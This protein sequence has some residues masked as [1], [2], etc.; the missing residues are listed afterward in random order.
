[1]GYKADLDR[2]Y[3][4]AINFAKY[5]GMDTTSAYST[6]DGSFDAFR[7]AYASAR[8]TQEYGENLAEWASWYRESI[9]GGGS[10]SGGSARDMDVAN[11][12]VGRS[13]AGEVTNPYETAQRALR[14]LVNGELTVINPP[15]REDLVILKNPRNFSECFGP[16][17]P[18]DMWPLD[19]AFAPDPNNPYKEFDHDAVLAKIWTKPISQIQ[20]N[21]TVASFDKGGHLVPGIVSRT[22]SNEAKN[23]LDFHGT[24]VTPGHVYYR[25]DSKKSHKFETLIDIL[26]D[27]GVIQKQNGTLIRAATGE[28][29][30]GRRDRFVKAV[31][32]SLNLDGSVDTKD[33]G[34]IRLGTRFVV[35]RGDGPMVWCVADLIEAGG[36]IVGDDELIRVGDVG[37]V[38]FYWEFDAILPKPEDFVLACSGTSLIEIY[39]AGEWEGERPHMPA[40]LVRDGGPVQPLPQAKLAGMPRNEPL[41]VKHKP[42]E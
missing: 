14:A 13:F 18:I 16:E 15:S 34:R 30:G 41:N 20:P 21:D 40:P 6:V 31:T 12:A 29:V 22:M 9:L 39:E 4:E 7:H 35:D 26:R 23:I 27:D 5:F 10:L 24:R 1:M 36:G 8:A 33:E 25:P 28:E 42:R 19:R 3:E 37:P 17:V 11:D 38:P 32:G 2:Y